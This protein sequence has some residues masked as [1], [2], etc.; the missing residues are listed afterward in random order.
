MIGQAKRLLELRDLERKSALGVRGGQIISCSS[1]KGGT[2]KTF[3]AINI[4]YA[5]SRMKKK[6]LVVDLDPNLS[7]TNI[8]L[9]VKTDKTLMLFYQN[10]KKLEDLVTPFDTNLYF[11][12][13]DSGRLDY[14]E[15]TPQKVENL[16]YELRLLSEKLDFIILD[17]ASGASES[18]MWF[19]ANSDKNIIVTTPEPTAVMDA[20]VIVK[21]LKENH[22]YND[23]I[24]IVNKALNKEEGNGAFENI[25]SAAKHFLKEELLFLG[26][27][28]F[29]QTVNKSIMEQELLLRKYPKSQIS[30]EILKMTHKLLKFLQMAN[31]NQRKSTND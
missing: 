20:Y 10:R 1:G 11:I 5:L 12:F 17:N 14:P 2:G 28:P 31:N 7:N 13:G 21:L 16:F 27:L 30:E 25:N 26:V 9:N 29:D 18:I 23:K 3:T 8:M 6:V 19:L 4:A 15:L 22:Y 24:I